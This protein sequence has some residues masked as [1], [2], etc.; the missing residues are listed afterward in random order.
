MKIQVDILT[1]PVVGRVRQNH[2]AVNDDASTFHYG[3]QIVVDDASVGETIH[4][5][6]FSSMNALCVINVGDVAFVVMPP[7]D[8]LPPTANNNIT[9]APGDFVVLP[10]PENVGSKK[11][12]IFAINAGDEGLAQYWI[13]GS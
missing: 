1:E 13:S 9:L 6:N 11:T 12:R 4:N 2:S 3:G 5:T 7:T 10:T 8:S